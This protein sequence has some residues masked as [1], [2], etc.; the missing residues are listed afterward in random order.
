MLD[1]P[2]WMSLTAGLLVSLYL[3]V[4]SNDA[5][6]TIVHPAVP[7][8]YAPERWKEDDVRQTAEAL[9]AHMKRRGTT[10][11]ITPEELPPKTGR[12]Y[13]VTGG[14]SA[15]HLAFGIRV[16]HACMYACSP[17]ERCSSPESAL[18]FSYDGF[19]RWYMPQEW[20]TIPPCCRKLSCAPLKPC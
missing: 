18:R 17:P 3:Y 20:Q 19:A 9:E 8:F 5:K 11:L 15:H 13:I 14:V 6:I 7:A 10:T 16:R 12:R 4:R 1:I 2:L